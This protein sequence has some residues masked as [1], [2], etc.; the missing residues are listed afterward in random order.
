MTIAQDISFILNTGTVN[1]VSLGCCSLGAASSGCNNVAIGVCSLSTNTAGS[2]NIALGQCALKSNTAGCS[3][4]ALGLS[5]LFSNTTGCN[6]IAIGHCSLYS[7]TIGAL[8]IAIGCEGMFCN[9]TGFGN[10]AVGHCTLRFNNSG[11]QNL[12][13]GALALRANTYGDKNIAIGGLALRSNTTGNHNIAMGYGAL[14]GNTTGGL[15]IAI[16][17]CAMRTGSSGNSN[18]AI[19]YGSNFCNTYGSCNI[20]IGH[21]TLF[22][23]R[24][25]CNNVAIGCLTLQGNSGGYN[26]IGIG[27]CAIQSNTTGYG[28]IAIGDGALG[29]AG[30]GLALNSRNTVIGTN[31]MRRTTCN[32]NNVAVGF[33]AFFCNTTG[34]GNTAIGTSALCFNTSGLCNIAIGNGAALCTTIGSYNVVIGSTTSVEIA[35]SNCYVVLADGAGTVRQVWS[36][37]GALS[38]GPTYTNFGTAGQVLCSNGPM[39][40]PAWATVASSGGGSAAGN[41]VEAG[42]FST[43]VSN[44]VGYSVPGDS[45]TTTYITTG[46]GIIATMPST[47]G[48]RY[49]IHSLHITNTAASDAEITGRFEHTMGTGGSSSTSITIDHVSFFASRLPVPSGSAVELFKKP[50]ILYPND[51]VRLQAT[52]ANGGGGVNNQL[53]A[54]MIY[55]ASTDYT[56]QSGNYNLASA[57]PANI[58][59]SQLSTGTTTATAYPSIIESVRVTNYS[60]VADYRITVFWTN[61]ANVIQSYL[62]YNMLIPAYST[63]EILEK[64][65]RITSGDIIKAV[66]EAPN[67]L[68]I[69]VSSKILTSTFI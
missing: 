53:F 60:N 21:C 19:G 47:T 63:V 57:S 41:F 37:T 26:N 44:Q 45:F 20:S 36:G 28:N 5:N 13:L 27:A 18:I 4:I 51:I 30:A 39:S 12:A 29:G 1:S 16:G 3:N 64:V 10:I 40:P 17:C 7:N 69:Q 15:N 55:E 8:N 54:Y 33:A 25:G 34:C 49:I 38:I 68:S 11:S 50:Q 35:T 24:T 9:T 56:Y 14:Y 46:T 58:Y 43:S 62:A 2:N 66:P 52:S 31:A 59:T 22:R 48:T 65:K 67:V 32:C 42:L 61:S 23:N 6:N